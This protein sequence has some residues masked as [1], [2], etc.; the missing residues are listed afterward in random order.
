MKIKQNSEMDTRIQ[1]FYINQKQF[2][3]FERCFFFGGNILG[4]DSKRKQKEPS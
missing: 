2:N 3:E 1:P 4:L